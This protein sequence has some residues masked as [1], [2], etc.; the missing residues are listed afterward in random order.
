MPCFFDANGVELKLGDFCVVEAGD[1]EEVGFVASL[2]MR[3]DVAHASHSLPKVR[4]LA[5]PEEIEKWKQLKKREREAID[6]CKE[7]VKKHGLTMK[8]TNVRFDER[9]NKVVFNF[10][11]DKRVDF[12]ELVRDLAAALKSRIELWQIG[13]RDEAKV[14]DGYGI[15]G[16]RLCCAGFIR[17]FV[18]ITIKMAKDQDI[19]L[20]PSKLSGVCGRLMCCLSY[21]ESLYHELSRG[22]PPIGA[23]VKTER[24]E[25]LV[26]DRNLVRQTFTIQDSAGHRHRVGRSDI[27]EVFIPENLEKKQME[28]K[29][30]ILGEE[31]REEVPPSDDVDVTPAAEA[32]SVEKSSGDSAPK[33]E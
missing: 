14:L 5:S 17:N 7:K 13:V 23:T 28:I 19:F 12:R 16:R 22:A 32:G 31:G 29:E 6:L 1:E 27:R 8:I 15:C 3:A 24:V 4:R 10:T 11:A 21:E 2:E 25:G 9:K 26:I 18:P 30:E 20:A 33:P